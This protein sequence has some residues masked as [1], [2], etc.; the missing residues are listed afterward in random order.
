MIV[1]VCDRPFVP[2]KC[3]TNYLGDLFSETWIRDNEGKNG[4]PKR[5]CLSERKT[6]YWQAELDAWLMRRNKKRGFSKRKA[7]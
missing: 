6:G 4:F 3:V 1:M 7:A 2:F 5:V